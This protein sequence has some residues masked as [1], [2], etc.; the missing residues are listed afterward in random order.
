LA[1]LQKV[2]DLNRLGIPS[3]IKRVKDW[4]KSL[5]LEAVVSKI[6][7]IRVM[8]EPIERNVR[9]G[10]GIWRESEACNQRILAGSSRPP[11]IDGVIFI[12]WQRGVFSTGHKIS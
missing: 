11:T 6:Q 9:A 10:F 4:N 12:V 5:H 1:V 2:V 8:K 3:V 7:N